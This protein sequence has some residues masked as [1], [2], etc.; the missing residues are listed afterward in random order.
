MLHWAIFPATCIATKLPDKLQERLL[1][2]T[3][4]LKCNI[5]IVAVFITQFC[6]NLVCGKNSTVQIK[7]P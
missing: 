1:S 2:V 3:A 4:P 5:S 6:F 7:I